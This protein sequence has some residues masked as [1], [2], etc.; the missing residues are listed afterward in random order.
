MI[1][2]T[3]CSDYPADG[4]GAYFDSSES[5]AKFLPIQEMT[6]NVMSHGVQYGNA[7]FE[8][9]RFNGRHFFKGLE[10]TIRLAKTA[11]I[12][13]MKFPTNLTVESLEDAKEE[14]ARRNG[15]TDAGYIRVWFG[16]GPEKF[17]VPPSDHPVLVT[18]AAWPW[19]TNTDKGVSVIIDDMRQPDPRT[20]FVEAKTSANYMTRSSLRQKASAAGFNDTLLLHLNDTVAECTASNIFFV[21]TDDTVVTPIAKGRM[22][23]GITR[24][25]VM[26]E[27]LP[28]LSIKVIER[29]IHVKEIPSMKAAFATG[30]AAGIV[31]IIKIH[32]QEFFGGTHEMKIDPITRDATT[33]YNCVLNN[34]KR[35]SGAVFEKPINDVAGLPIWRPDLS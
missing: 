24:L 5:K 31:P 4:V 28:A 12:L 25:T 13:G 8:G 29:D 11:A 30:S 6:I 2:Q 19:I 7:G 15:L 9:E 18:I 20:A 16:R 21:Q 17:G 26:K 23:D 10:H 1:P 14:V 34:Y 33:A 22:L 32:S 35:P 3:I 27:V